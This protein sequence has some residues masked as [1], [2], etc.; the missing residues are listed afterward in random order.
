MRAG[1]VS[2]AS[3]STRTIYHHEFG[4]AFPDEERDADIKAI[5][6]CIVASAHLHCLNH[7]ASLEASDPSTVHKGVAFEFG[8]DSYGE[9]HHNHPDAR[10]WS[11]DETL[12]SEEDEASEGE[13]D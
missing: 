2:V 7:G 6:N 8:E 13:E 10:G 1:V 11:D 4:D 12:S 3:H 5:Y 9:Y